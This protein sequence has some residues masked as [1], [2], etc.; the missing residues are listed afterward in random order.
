MIT[1]SFTA[2]SPDVRRMQVFF[3]SS[4]WPTTSPIRIR[5][6]VALLM[7]NAIVES[8]GPGIP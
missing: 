3:E 5:S 1:S 6:L 4:S 2:R 8:S 7:G